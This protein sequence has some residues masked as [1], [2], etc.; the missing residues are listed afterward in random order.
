MQNYILSAT[1]DAQARR[2]G[3]D[4]VAA[5]TATATPTA[6]SIAANAPTGS[7][8]DLANYLTDGYWAD[9][10]GAR[11]TFDTSISN[12]ITVNIAGLT[13]DGQRLARWAM[14]AWEAV[15]DIQF[16]ETSGSAQIT[17]TDNQ[18][19]AYSSYYAFGGTTQSAIINVS[20]SWL[21]AYG[22]QI[23]DYSFS[24]Y[25]HELGHA[26]GLGH[27][28]DYNGA[29][30]YGVDETF[31]NDSYQVSL[32]SYFSQTENTTVNA[33]YGLPA[34]AMIADIMA[35]QALYGAPSGSSATAGNTIYGVGQTIGGYF[36][37]L[38]EAM[39]AG[40]DP[41]NYYGDGPIAMTLYDQGGTDTVDLSTD[42]NDQSVDLNGGGIWNVWG[43][44]G[45][46]VVSTGTVLENYIAGSGND[47]VLGNAVGNQLSGGG[48]NDTLSGGDGADTL[49]GGPGSDLLIGGVGRDLVSYGGAG[50]GLL[51]DLQFAFAN[52][53]EA[54]GD[55]YAE[56]EDIE[57]SAYDDDLRGNAANNQ[58]I[59]GAGNDFLYGRDGDDTL[60][61]GAGND[62]LVGG[63]GADVLNGGAGWNR[64]SYWTS[65]VDL[66][67][68]LQF[69]FVNTGIA[70]GDSYVGIQD[71]Q[72]S[73]G[74]D[75][76]RGNNYNN[77]IWGNAG[78]DVLYGRDGD[79]RLFGY[80]GDD[81]LLGNKGAD[82][83]NGG[84]GIDRASYWTATAGVTADLLTPTVNTG[85][86]AGDTYVQIEDLQG[87]SYDDILRGDNAANGIWGAAGDDM[88]VGRG[89][90]DYLE[91]HVGRDTLD[92]GAGD[93]TL[94][95][96]GDADTFIFNE[97]RD[98]I[99]DFWNDI[100]QIQL[101]AALWGGQSLSALQIISTYASVT[102][103]NTV[104]DFGNGNT[105][106]INSLANPD[107]LADDLLIV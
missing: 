69:T 56:I 40:N 75:E 79:D 71:I 65:S 48:G 92:G 70:A 30:T 51:A 87:S 46:I 59:G 84:D 105:L 68:D 64:I 5:A 54:A 72:G 52:T 32:M 82:L 33:S 14:E 6:P 63:A 22:T 47:S 98:V 60:L 101:D 44:I 91:G 77:N 38:L 27:Q 16:A 17:F 15:A 55:T 23:D 45:N 19:G 107:L 66:L 11:H 21:N 10:G 104:L 62:I 28:G 26:L 3:S 93:D 18:P 39:F 103:G 8:E 2:A 85:E 42:T 73:A 9:N 99:Q 102:N 43:R 53:G 37:T 81:T 49:L 29:A 12:I 76:I 74:N 78:N 58:V 86:A 20:T 31:A 35:I 80:I 94:R 4:H 97:G 50:A 7:L 67:A 34:T 95:G 90:N 25:L 41:L 36:G 61:G 24:T 89:G 83:L 88:I 13:A 57:G 96:G 1:A 106:T 100:D